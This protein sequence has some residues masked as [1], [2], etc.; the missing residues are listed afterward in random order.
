MAPGV[1]APGVVSLLAGG[2]VVRGRV[3]VVVVIVGAGGSATWHWMP[4]L[5]RAGFTPS[6]SVKMSDAHR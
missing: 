2:S 3:V 1:V 4:A 5:K 6:G